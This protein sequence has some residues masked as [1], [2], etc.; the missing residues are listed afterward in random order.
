MQL[1]EEDEASLLAATLGVA[2]LTSAATALA[3]G[4]RTAAVPTAAPAAEDSA[5][6]GATAANAATTVTISAS[7]EPFDVAAAAAS[8]AAHMGV[9]AGGYA[10]LSLGMGRRGVQVPPSIYYTSN[11]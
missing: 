6:T 3:A 2:P 10:E 9:A 1:V 7:A 5:A 4:R 11:C 8:L